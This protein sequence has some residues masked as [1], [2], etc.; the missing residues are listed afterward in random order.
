VFSAQYRCMRVFAVA[1][2]VACSSREPERVEP[3]KPTASV[4]PVCPKGADET[5]PWT[6]EVFPGCPPAQLRGMH[7]HCEG[8]APKPCRM[9]VERGG[10][11]RAIAIEYDAAGRYARML[12]NREVAQTCEYDQAGRMKRCRDFRGEATL[13]RDAKGRLVRVVGAD[14][15]INRFKYD[16]HGRIVQVAGAG[17]E[18]TLPIY[19]ATGTLVQEQI[20]GG[21]IIYRFDAHG[22]VT[23][24]ET[25]AFRDVDRFT[26]DADGRVAERAY[27]E[28]RETFAYD[29]K[30][31]PARFTRADAG[32]VREQTTVEYCD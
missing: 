13:E 9:T 32:K 1:M 16:E 4:M 14:G 5:Q 22:R 24:F 3:P 27:G 6:H 20:A 23:H 26:Y 8:L 31:R 21:E 29:S 12:D 19:D 25:Q 7:F 30:G 11:Q 10:K 18:T 28:T 2:L 17:G 15:E